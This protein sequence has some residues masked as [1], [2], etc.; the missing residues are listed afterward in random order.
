[1]GDKGDDTLRDNA[2]LESVGSAQPRTHRLCRYSQRS[3]NDT[4]ASI[5]ACVSSLRFP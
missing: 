5:D 4:E 1:M 2:L 3:L